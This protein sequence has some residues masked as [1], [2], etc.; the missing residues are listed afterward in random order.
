MSEYSDEEME[1]IIEW[2]Q[3][4]ADPE[5]LQIIEEVLDDEEEDDE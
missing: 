2:V 1:E 3:E 4:D 5:D